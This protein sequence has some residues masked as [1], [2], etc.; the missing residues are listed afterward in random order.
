[1]QAPLHYL[2]RLKYSL[3]HGSINN[4]TIDRELGEDTTSFIGHCW[5]HYSIFSIAF[6]YVLHFWRKE[7]LISM[8]AKTF[9]ARAISHSN[10]FNSIGLSTGLVVIS[11]IDSPWLRL[12]GLVKLKLFFELYLRNWPQGCRKHDG[13]PSTKLSWAIFPLMI[14]YIALQTA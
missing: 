14:C 10:Q 2:C 13:L 5:P 8:T 9:T 7:A 4:R 3:S 12:R 1:M 11:D 6:K